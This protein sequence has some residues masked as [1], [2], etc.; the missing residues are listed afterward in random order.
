MKTIIRTLLIVL[1]L[2]ATVASAGTSSYV[3]DPFWM[4]DPLDPGQPAPDPA[5][6][7]DTVVPGYWWRDTTNQNAIAQHTE[8]QFTGAVYEPYGTNKLKAFVYAATG[9]ANV[10]AV[11]GTTTWLL[12]GSGGGKA[13]ANAAKIA[14]Q[15][16]YPGISSKKLLGVI[17]TGAT[18]EE[19]WGTTYWRNT[20]RYNPPFPIN[21]SAALTA[22]AAER[23]AVGTAI[24]AREDN[25]YGRVNRRVTSSQMY[26]D[27]MG[28]G[29]DTYLGAGSMKTYE[30]EIPFY[31]GPNVLYSEETTLYV[32]GNIPVTLIPTSDRDAGLIVWLP[33]QQILIGD[34]GRYLPDAGSIHQPSVSIPER[35]AELD[36]MIGLAPTIFIPQHGLPI[37]GADVAAAAL[38]AQREALQSIYDQALVRINAG[39]TIDEAAAAV[40]LPADLAA[41]PYNQELVSTI[42]GIVRN[43]YHD[44]LGWF[45]GETHELASTLTPAA[46]AAAL[47]YALGGTDALTAAARTAELNARDL[48][49]A[50][51]AL[52]LAEVAYEAAPEDFTA[53]R[54]YAQ[55]LR[56]NAF[57]QKSA[58]IR[59]YYLVVAQSLGVE[60]IVTDLAKT[61]DENVA[62]AFSADD[63][64]GHF[65]GISGASLQTV[66]VVSLPLAEHGVLSLAGAPVA[67]GQEIPLAELDG[68]AF[69]PAGDWNGETAFTWNGA[70]GGVYAVTGANVTITIMAMN[71]AP[72][73]SSPLADV[74]VDE[75]ALSATYDLAAV[76]TDVDGDPLTY[77]AESSNPALVA[78][79]LDGAILTLDFQAEQNGQA[80]ITVSA[81]DATGEET[82]AWATDDFLVTVNPVNDAP[83]AAGQTQLVTAGLARTFTLNYRDVETARADLA[84]TFSGPAHGTLDTSA[85]P[86]V[87]Y[88]A[89]AD[90]IGP[91]SFTYTV[92]D[93]G[94]PDG[95]TPAVP[96]A[97]CTGALQAQATVSL[98][99]AENSIKGR[100]YDDANANGSPDEGEGGVAGVTVRLISLSAG[101]TV[102]LVSAADGT[103]AF[104]S[105]EPGTYQVRQVLLPGYV[106]TTPDPA[107]IDLIMGQAVGGVDFGV[108]QSADLGVTMTADV[109]DKTIIYTLV[110]TNNWPAEALEA[111]LLNVRPHGVSYTSIITNRGA[112]QGGQTVTCEFGP[113][114]AGESATVTIQ[115]NRTDKNNPI[116]NTAT[117]TASTFDIVLLNN[118]AT[119]IVQ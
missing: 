109:N 73:V 113:L 62:L 45:G 27:T 19:T 115:A 56:K 30:A 68:L 117:V 41:N 15:T 80:T 20:F 74:A 10:T 12:V 31:T 5:T 82:A 66:K 84:V 116:E 51:Q 52:Y 6:P 94:D 63:F 2:S 48:A 25:I 13:E 54:V 75:D 57:M 64:S 34:A 47:A 53:K 103:Y 23:S 4:P 79:T 59:N 96:G 118:S 106:Q 77:A 22:A 16:K 71:D 110:V 29:P 101:S 14:L 1:A 39:D 58:Q 21:A 107:D 60:T 99:V 88:T 55:A 36:R 40:A 42:S 69:T 93:R 18:P 8:D 70:T 72:A 61:G 67:A 105:L 92:T 32:D 7:P 91:D 46:K 37:S 108:V 89:P 65:F 17:L 119:V 44:K 111:M 86:L 97:P 112:C 50:E 78:A 33:N 98:D 11:V 87:T 3:S 28:W 38:T 26:V 85:L 102:E 49:G 9:G 83:S 100:V 76:F 43:L 90:Y 114:A 35:I 95:C 81:A 24:T 104:G